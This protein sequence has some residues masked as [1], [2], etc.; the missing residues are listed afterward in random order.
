MT[1]KA[2][3]ILLINFVLSFFCG[4]A[5]RNKHK[6]ISKPAN[7]VTEILK[8]NRNSP[9][10]FVLWKGNICSAYLTV[11]L[12]DIAGGIY[13]S[14][15]IHYWYEGACSWL[16]PDYAANQIPVS[17][18]GSFYSSLCSLVIAASWQILII[19]RASLLYCKI[20]SVL[21]LYT[22]LQKE[23][24]A[25][26]SH[27]AAVTLPWIND[28]SITVTNISTERKISYKGICKLLFIH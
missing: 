12:A 14:K 27:W 11:I 15:E 4:L 26:N 18:K 5:T 3:L 13:T 23:I 21:W 16:K 10:K 2:L 19:E 22:I 6:A 24:Y 8:K 17:G 7:C 20:T 9:C 1:P 28:T 25:H